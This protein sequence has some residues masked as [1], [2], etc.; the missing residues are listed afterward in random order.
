MPVAQALSPP[1]TASGEFRRKT[2]RRQIQKTIERL[3][4][5][6]ACEPSY[7]LNRNSARQPRSKL[8]G[9]RLNL[10][11]RSKVLA[12]A[13]G[14]DG[15]TAK[16]PGRIPSQARLGTGI[17]I[18]RHVADPASQVGDDIKAQPARALPLQQTPFA[19]PDDRKGHLVAQL[20]FPALGLSGIRN[21]VGDI[22]ENFGQGQGARKTLVHFPDITPVVFADAE[23]HAKAGMAGMGPVALHQIAALGIPRGID[24]LA[25]YE[26]NGPLGGSVAYRGEIVLGVVGPAAGFCQASGRAGPA[27]CQ[28]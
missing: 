22:L 20:V 27:V 14:P 2:R 16:V 17:G 13:A 24:T 18:D 4:E 25:K 1:W 26:C 8:R 23:S 15:T 28:L 9:W 6:K 11:S 19:P 5:P 3:T 10:K 21:L 12:A 7:C